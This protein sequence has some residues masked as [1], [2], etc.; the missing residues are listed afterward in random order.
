MMKK[1]QILNKDRIGITDFSFGFRL[2]LALEHM[3]M[4]L[5][6]KTFASN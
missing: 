3:H 6:S 4:F 5:P 1:Y 2:S